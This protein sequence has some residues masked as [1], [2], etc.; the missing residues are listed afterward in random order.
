MW[1]APS[2][3]IKRDMD[4]FLRRWARLFE[5]MAEKSN[6]L[7]QADTVLITDFDSPI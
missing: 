6:E 4:D 3:C 1:S 2:H 5:Q 7:I